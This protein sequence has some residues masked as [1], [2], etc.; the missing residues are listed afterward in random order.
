[1]DNINRNNIFEDTELGFLDVVTLGTAV[2]QVLSYIENLKQTSTD[3][4]MKELKFQDKELF[5]KILENQEEIK[6]KLD[7]LENLLKKG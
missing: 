7:R 4:L 5:G 2:L 3:S 1:M 6:Q